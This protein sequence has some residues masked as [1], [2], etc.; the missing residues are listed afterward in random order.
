MKIKILYLV[1]ILLALLCSILLY[2][3][4]DR[5]ITLSYSN[6]GCESARGD[7]DNVIVL[8]ERDW[9]GMEKEKVE[10]KL[11]EAMD[12]K[13]LEKNLVKIEDDLIWYGNVRFIFSSGR[14]MSIEY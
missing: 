12:G 2:L 3:F 10:H 6:Q 7:I 1:I 8:I 13:N 4:I 9:A 14:L 11:K 5:L